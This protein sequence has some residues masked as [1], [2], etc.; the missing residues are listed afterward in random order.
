MPDAI[1]L[2]ASPR[3]LLLRQDRIGDV[4]VSTPALCAIRKQF[5]SAS[6]DYVLS[7]NNA[8]AAFALREHTNRVL[9]F[10]KN[11]FEM[12]RLLWQLRCAAYDL[13]IDFNHTA[14]TTSNFLIKCINAKYSIAL[15]T[16]SPSAA[17]C[18]V[19]QGDRTSRHI[20][21]VLCD[22]TIPLG[23]TIPLSER[24]LSLPLS[25]R[26]LQE[27]KQRLRGGHQQPVLAVQI[28]GSSADRMYPADKLQQVIESVQM[29]FPELKIVI[30]SAP[31]ERDVSQKLAH[32]T[33]TTYIDTPGSYEQFAAIIAC[34]DY[35]LS[36]DTAA[37]HVAAAHGVPSVV[38]FSKDPRGYL[39]WLPYQS[40]CLPVITD[41]TSL[42][43]VPVHL[44]T[45][46]V[47]ELLSR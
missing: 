8:A 23:I 3:I 20:V 2:P 1:V 30:V 38:L 15:K 13:V 24:R 29:R 27:A 28:S 16:S 18:V 4:F 6:I 7:R 14:S 36:P 47:T 34:C 33:G 42:A 25:E 21:D 9:V 11:S 26:V 5:P 40:V 43:Q 12:L 35:L 31:G 44:V 32:V 46:K 10:R 39:N 45:E 22:L 41:S 17:S 37:I 19:E